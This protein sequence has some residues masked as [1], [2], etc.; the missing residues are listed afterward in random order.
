MIL[1]FDRCWELTF[2]TL[3]CSGEGKL[4]LIAG[5]GIWG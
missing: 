1:G 4:Y 2:V 5:V 3:V